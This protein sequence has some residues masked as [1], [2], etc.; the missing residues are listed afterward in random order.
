MPVCSYRNSLY[1]IS[2]DLFTGSQNLLIMTG[3]HI[4]LQ[5]SKEID[6]FFSFIELFQMKF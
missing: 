4:T 1:E 5:T 6:V 3:I 2:F